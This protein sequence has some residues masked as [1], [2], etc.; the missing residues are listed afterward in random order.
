MK[1]AG[2]VML[3]LVLVLGSV[4]VYADEI[5]FPDVSRVTLK[6]AKSMLGDKDIIILDVRPEEQWSV[7]DMKI[8][9][10]VHED[11]KKIKTWLKNYTP[12]QTII[13]YCA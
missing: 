12:A 5:P 3:V 11:P 6:A 7:A 10:A 2:V 13:L 9:R 1:A 4:A 8:A